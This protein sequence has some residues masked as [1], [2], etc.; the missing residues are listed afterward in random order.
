MDNT[1]SRPPYLSNVFK[2]A[3]QLS[4]FVFNS[5]FCNDDFYRDNS[6]EICINRE[7]LAE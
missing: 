5:K 3:V 6:N 4:Y 1:P 7:L 2:N